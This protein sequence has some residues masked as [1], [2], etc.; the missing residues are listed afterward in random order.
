MSLITRY[1]QRLIHTDKDQYEKM[2]EMQ[3]QVFKIEVEIISITGNAEI[4]CLGQGIAEYYISEQKR[5][6]DKYKIQSDN[7]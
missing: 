4:S 2:C 1:K 7:S 5:T 6:D 3:R